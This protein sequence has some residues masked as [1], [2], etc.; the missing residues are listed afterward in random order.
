M[1]NFS[2]QAM[3]L[4]G[5]ERNKS[6]GDPRADYAR[7]AKVWSGIL[8]HEVTPLQAALCMAGLKLVR[9]GFRHK[10]DNLV[11]A[12]GYLLVAESIVRDE[13]P[14]DFIGRRPMPSDFIRH[15]DAPIGAPHH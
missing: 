11:D 13:S 2:E 12:H 5:G 4:V 14:Q 15:P 6:Y 10:D 1:K 3:A 9:E 7:V 8:G